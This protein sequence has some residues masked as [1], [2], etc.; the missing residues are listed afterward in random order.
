MAFDM[1]GLL[2]WFAVM[3]LIAMSLRMTK[4]DSL[5]LQYIEI[6]ESCRI[7]SLESVVLLM[8]N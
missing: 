1:D 8:N 4:N 6:M 2:F 5:V 3:D 7:L